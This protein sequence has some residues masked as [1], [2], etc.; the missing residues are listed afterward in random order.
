MNDINWNDWLSREQIALDD[1]LLL[2]IGENPNAPDINTDWWDGLSGDDY[3]ERQAEAEQ[4]IKHNQLKARKINNN[5]SVE[6]KNINPLAFFN[7][8]RSN[9]WDLPEYL[10]DW[11]DNLEKQECVT[12]CGEIHP[13][14]PLTDEDKQHYNNRAAWSWVDAIYIL[15]GY[16]PAYQLSTEQVRSHF[17][18]WVKYFTDSLLLGTV[19][20]ETIQAGQRIFI[21]S[22]TNWQAFW[23]NIHK[24]PEPETEGIGDV[25]QSNP[26][27]C[28]EISGL[29]S[30]P[31]RQDDWFSV[32][33]DTTKVLHDELSKMP[34]EAQVWGRM[35]TEPPQ[36]YAVTSGKDK[37]EDCLYMPGAKLLSRSAFTKRWKSYSLAPNK[38]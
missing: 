35:A 12:W 16:K 21:D 8:A 28:I 18:D 1:C 26:R 10:H 2:A 9:D 11:L 25:I 29:L 30:S 36:G 37:G 20:R 33:D 14:E 4:W 5:G 19:G 38:P 17:P 32:I 3:R 34:N 15:Q 27:N 6:Y 24:R 7:L 23:Q 13:L 22:P 31:S